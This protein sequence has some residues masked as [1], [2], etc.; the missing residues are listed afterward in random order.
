M[1]FITIAVLTDGT[2]KLLHGPEVKPAVQRAA[3]QGFRNGNLPEGV[4]RVEMW[5]RSVVKQAVRQPELPLDE[6]AKEEEKTPA[7]P[8]SGRT[9]GGKFAA[10]PKPAAASPASTTPP[11][12]NGAPEQTQV[13]QPAQ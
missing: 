6:P 8:K 2:S 3:V 13:Q 12:G 10:K 7:A 9:P 5:P 11:A 1:K 4:D